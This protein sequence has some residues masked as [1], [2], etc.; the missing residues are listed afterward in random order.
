MS[1]VWYAKSR[2]GLLELLDNLIKETGSLSI[3]VL[4]EQE[5]LF[6]ANGSANQV[7]VAITAADKDK[8][9]VINAMKMSG[10]INYQVTFNPAQSSQATKESS[11]NTRRIGDFCSWFTGIIK[12]RVLVP[13][14]NIMMDLT[15]S[16]LESIAN[17]NLKHNAIIKIPRLCILEIERIAN[18]RGEQVKKGGLTKQRE[19]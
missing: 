12:N 1:E 16:S 5:S 3:G 9:D 14:T 11:Q 7:T 17:I 10:L 4:H 15:F 19:R 2:V 6:T 18:E 8:D 13:D